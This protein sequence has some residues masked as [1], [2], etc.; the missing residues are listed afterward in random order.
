MYLLVGLSC[1]SITQDTEWKR[2]PLN[3]DSRS[4]TVVRLSQ[5]ES[6]S[7]IYR[8]LQYNVS[9]AAKSRHQI[10]QV[11]GKDR[12]QENLPPFLEPSL[13]LFHMCWHH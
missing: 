2:R 5:Y 12:R 8:R 13:L 6:R 10:D 9:P 3:T 11:M 1:Q 4:I 7:C